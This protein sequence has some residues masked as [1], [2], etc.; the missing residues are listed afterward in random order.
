MCLTRLSTSAVS[1]ARRQ[2]PL[3]LAISSS[4]RPQ[5]KR[6]D[7]AMVWPSCPD[8]LCRTMPGLP[9]GPAAHGPP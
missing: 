5:D 4:G 6:Y 3:S 2:R 7:S 1:F 8:E 9:R